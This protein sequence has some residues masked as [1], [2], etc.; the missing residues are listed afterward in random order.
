MRLIVKT[1]IYMQMMKKRK[2]TL[3]T[4]LMEIF[5]LKWN[6][7][8]SKWKRPIGISLCRVNGGTFLRISVAFFL[9]PGASVRD[10]SEQTSKKRNK[11]EWKIIIIYCMISSVIGV[12]IALLMQLKAMMCVC[13][14]SNIKHANRLR[15]MFWK[16]KNLETQIKR[17][18]KKQRRTKE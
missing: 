17:T 6:Y 9:R 4:L 18:N 12:Y 7:A 10:R 11:S 8:I 14:A 1:T 16:T 15:P 5:Q 2:N 3:F 13:A